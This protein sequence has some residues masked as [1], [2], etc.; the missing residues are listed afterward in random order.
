M[1]ACNKSKLGFTLIELLMVVMI[2]G[3]L[4]SMALPQY[5]EAIAKS[6]A[7]EAQ[8]IIS[9]FMRSADAYLLVAPE[10]T[11]R[12]ASLLKLLD[13][14]VPSDKYE[15]YTY[16]RGDS[17]GV[18]GSAYFRISPKS[19]K[20][21]GDWRIYVLRVTSNN[22]WTKHCYWID[23]L[24]KAVCDGLQTSA[25]YTVSNYYGS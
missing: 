25:G 12:D 16:A 19:T 18:S 1:K 15:Y 21:W 9:S 17:T 4:A 23:R 22:T 10:A 13:V 24:G 7:A 5:K 11:E 3:I 2:I 8:V 14:N 6:R 20:G